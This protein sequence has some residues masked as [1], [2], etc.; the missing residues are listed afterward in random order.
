MYTDS[1][2]CLHKSYDTQAALT[3]CQ[4]EE[5]ESV[6]EFTTLIE[7]VNYACGQGQILS[8]QVGVLMVLLVGHHLIEFAQNRTAAIN[9]YI[10]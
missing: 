8:L 6:L 4:D 5:R 1:H 3:Q 9:S 7:L 2:M 10:V